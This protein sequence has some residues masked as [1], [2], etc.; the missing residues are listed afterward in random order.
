MV[1]KIIEF[2]LI[3]E[4]SPSEHA[5]F[6]S[7]VLVQQNSPMNSLDWIALGTKSG[8]AALRLASSNVFSRSAVPLT[9][10]AVAEGVV[11]VTAVV[12]VEEQN[13]IM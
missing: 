12:P 6:Y 5:L 7:V 10:A 1:I 4:P 8:A 11:E 3:D 2:F 13:K 9:G